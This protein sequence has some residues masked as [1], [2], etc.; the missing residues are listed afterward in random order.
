[1]LPDRP[2]LMLVERYLRDTGMAAT[3]FGRR[4]SRDPRLVFDLR[5]GRTPGD[6]LRRSIEHFMNIAKEKRQ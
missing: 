5:R 2:L 1:M 4:A 6:R 3:T